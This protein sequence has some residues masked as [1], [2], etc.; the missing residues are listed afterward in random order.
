MTTTAVA[1]LI[2]LVDLETTGLSNRTSR[3]IQ[4]GIVLAGLVYFES[5]SGIVL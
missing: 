3:I 2:V 4:V 5:H 1:P